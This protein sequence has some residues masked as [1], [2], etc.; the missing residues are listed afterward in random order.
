MFD[1]KLK[2]FNARCLDGVALITDRIIRKY[3]TGVDIAEGYL[4]TGKTT[5]Y[6]TDARYFYSAKEKL[7]AVGVKS[8]LYKGQED[9]IDFIKQ[10]DAKILF[11]DYARTTVKEYYNYNH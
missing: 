6:F 8:M 1:G 9:L 3:L 11:I 7:D 10:S 2:A 4:L 5:A